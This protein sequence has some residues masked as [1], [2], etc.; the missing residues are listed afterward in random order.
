MF[1]NFM[2]KHFPRQLIELPTIVHI[3]KNRTAKPHVHLY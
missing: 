1:T 2:M 3:K